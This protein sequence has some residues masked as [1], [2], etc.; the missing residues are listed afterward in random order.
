MKTT[1][2]AIEQA[3]YDVVRRHFITKINGLPNRA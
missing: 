2:K 3:A 1:N